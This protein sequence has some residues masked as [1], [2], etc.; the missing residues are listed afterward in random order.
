MANNV[1]T[2]A[3]LTM[4]LQKASSHLTRFYVRIEMSSQTALKPL[5]TARMILTVSSMNDTQL[6]RMGFLI[7]RIFRNMQNNCWQ[8][9]NAAVLRVQLE[10]V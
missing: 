8:A 7:G 10:R 6:S 2:S 5:L 3:V 9:G 1:Q 4:A